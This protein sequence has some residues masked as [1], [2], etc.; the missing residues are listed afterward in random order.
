MKKETRMRIIHLSVAVLLTAALAVSLGVF[1]ARSADLN[2]ELGALY[3]SAYYE[4]VDNMGDLENK[5]KKLDVA[6]GGKLQRELLEG[7]YTDSEVAVG[8]IATLSGRNG[9]ITPA[10]KFVNQL[11]DYAGYLSKKAEAEGLTAD[12]KDTLRELGEIVGQLNEAFLAAGESVAEG[13]NIYAALGDELGAI[14]DIYEAVSDN[15][16]EYPELIYDGPFSDGLNDRETKF[17]NGKETITADE[18]VSVAGEIFGGEFSYAGES[19]FSIPS[20]MLTSGERNVRVTKAGG[21]VLQYS[22]GSA[23]S[24]SESGSGKT[25]DEIITSAGALLNELGYSDMQGVWASE[26]DD[27]VYINFAFV[28]DDV[29]YYPDLIKVKASPETGAVIGIEAMNYIYNHTERP[30]PVFADIEIV[31]PEGFSE[32]ARKRAVIPTDFNTEIAVYEV[33]GEY[34]N[35]TYYV[36]FDG[37]TG[38]ETEVMRVI[39]DGNQGMLIV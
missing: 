16:V 11:G 28:R 18:A 10:L 30:S 9:E 17:L 34:E 21:Y 27:A 3:D 36:Y 12:E 19:D 4:L 5:L 15:N 20:Y 38:E 8:Y 39:E 37:V 1:A 26:S 35:G 23:S 31:L 2:T 7:I 14:G 24:G 32:S 33:S 22:D 29:V 25:L 6:T 13:G